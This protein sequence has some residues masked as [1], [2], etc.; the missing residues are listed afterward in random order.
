MPCCKYLLLAHAVPKL[1][2]IFKVCDFRMLMLIR[3]VYSIARDL[4][5]KCS[6]EVSFFR[7]GQPQL[8]VSSICTVYSIAGDLVGEALRTVLVQQLADLRSRCDA[9]TEKEASAM[10]DDNGDG[11]DSGDAEL[12]TVQNQVR[13]PLAFRQY[14]H[15]AGPVL[16]KKSVFGPSF[17]H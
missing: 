9:L 11:S 12:K 7:S 17:S 5:M 13:L 6:R 2:C 14:A 10:S 3:I 4:K 15:Y 1:Y 8:H 16:L